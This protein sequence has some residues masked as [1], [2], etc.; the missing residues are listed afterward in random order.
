MNITTLN[1]E[2]MKRGLFLVIKIFFIL[3]LLLTF[4]SPLIDAT[5]SQHPRKIVVFKEWFDNEADQDALLRN[6][7]A[8][9]IKHLR[10]IN[11]T[12]AYLHSQAEKGL[13][14]R[15]EVSRIDEDLTINALDELSMAKP[16]PPQ[17]LEEITWGIVRIYA[18]L[19][20]EKTTGSPIKVAILDTGID[21]D[22]PDLE[23]NIKGNVNLIK[24]NK[25]GDDDKGH[26]THVAG[27]VAA[28]DNDIGVIGIGPDISLYAV[29]VLDK[30]GRGWLSDLIDGLNWCIN[31]EM[32]VINMS[33]GSLRDNESFHEA[34]IE[35]YEA[36]I[37]QIASAGNNGEYGGAIEY[38]AKYPETIAVSA[39]D[40]YENFAS[41][42][43]FGPEI[44]LIAP[45]VDIKSA[46]KRDAYETLSGTSM[47]APHV[48]GVVAL[49]LTTRPKK[50]DLDKDK[51]WDPYEIKI[52]LKENA[53]RLGLDSNQQGAG[54]VRA[55]LAVY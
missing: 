32:Q 7:G 15:N 38:P 24:P 45:G 3:V 11:G 47:S 20:W 12:A 17:P 44:D 23:G 30:K 41:F 39:M 9:K 22:H 35:T 2:I 21:L 27:I 14:G 34:I 13:K 25:S 54:L 53:E 19:A 28:L 50:Y 26:G 1:E 42:S 4:S 55:D 31:N 52:K 18:E 10:L 37:T 5:Q 8:V 46:Y 51:V 16:K 33:F 29:K 43:S 6:S 48:A 36:G 40:Q 49:M